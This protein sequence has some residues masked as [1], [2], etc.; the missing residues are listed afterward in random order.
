MDCKTQKGLYFI[1]IGLIVTMII[2][3]ITSLTYFFIEEPTS[4]SAVTDALGFLSFIGAI[5]VLIGTIFFLLGREEF[6]EK[7]QNNVKNAVI[8]FCINL[9][10]VIGFVSAISFMMFSA[11][12]TSSTEGV[13]MSS[14]TMFVIMMIV[15]A[16]LGGLMYYFALIYLEDEHGKKVLFAAVISSIAISIITAIYIAGLLGEIFGSISTDASSY[17]SSVFTQ[18]VGG[19]SI[20]GLIPNLLYIY[21]IYVPY[22]RIK[23]GELVPVISSSSGGSAP[24]RVCPNC[25]K[26]IPDDVNI[27]PYCGKNFG[28]SF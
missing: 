5:I 2:S 3:L 24:S 12:T 6:G 13:A 9:I 18:N 7:H 20:L 15:S 28:D 17:S 22:R 8:I 26:N 19:I 1:M 25:N 10:V 21:S 27:C 23:D 16:V 11:V 14:P 4:S